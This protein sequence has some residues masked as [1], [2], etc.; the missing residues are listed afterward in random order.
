MKYIQS[1]FEKVNNYHKYVITQLKHGVKL[2]SAQNMNI[3]RSTINQTIKNKQ[4]KRH[5]L[6]LPYAGNKGEKIL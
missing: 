6:I 1:T 3:E 4:E 5:L 2:K